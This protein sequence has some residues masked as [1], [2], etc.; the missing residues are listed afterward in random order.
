MQET[1]AII[2]RVWQLSP[3]LQRLELTVE[4]SLAQLSPGQLLLALPQARHDPYLREQWIPI[5]AS[6]GMIIVERHAGDVYTP[7]QVV[8]LL[9]PVGTEMPFSGGGNKRLLL[10]AQ[11]TSPVPLL[12][13]AQKAIQHTSEVTLVL[14]GSATDYPFAGIPAAVEVINGGDEWIWPNREA[15]LTWADQI[16]VTAHDAFWYDHLSNFFQLVKRVRGHIP[17]NILFGVFSN[18]PMP[19]GTGACGACLIRCK[20]AVKAACTQGPAFDLTEVHL[21]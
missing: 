14:L 12:M 8:N 19:C 7:G 6:D 3:R 20:T 13:L 11:D 1:E 17:V 16:F 10:I 5:D 15:T 4:P 18:L 9:G 2:E 21:A